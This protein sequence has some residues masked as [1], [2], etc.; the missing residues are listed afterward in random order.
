MAGFRRGRSVWCCPL[1]NTN[2]NI[3]SPT[4]LNEMHWWV[5]F[6]QLFLMVFQRSGRAGYQSFMAYIVCTAGLLAI[7][8]WPILDIFILFGEAFHSIVLLLWVTVC[9]VSPRAIHLLMQVRGHL[10]LM[11]LHCRYRIILR[12]EPLQWPSV[13]KMDRVS[14]QGGRY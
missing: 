2:T 10:V 5:D 4:E 12:H 7:A 11:Q 13:R 14:V 9:L 3:G 8:R 1:T 6:L